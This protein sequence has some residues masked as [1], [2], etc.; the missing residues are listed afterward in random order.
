M[1]AWR[2]R[3]VAFWGGCGRWRVVRIAEGEKRAGIRGG[4]V[5]GGR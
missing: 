2:K 3:T 4:R 5:E 1:E